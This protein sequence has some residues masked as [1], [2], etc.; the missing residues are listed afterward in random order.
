M[1][2]NNRTSIKKHVFIWTQCMNEKHCDNP[3]YATELRAELKTRAKSEFAK[4]DVRIN[5][6]G[7][8]GVC[9][10]GIHAVIYP[11]GKWFKK[12]SKEAINDVINYLKSDT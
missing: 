10:E 4:N 3:N 8:L 2:E 1:E 7:C 9:D 12:L 6:S 5:A 11:E